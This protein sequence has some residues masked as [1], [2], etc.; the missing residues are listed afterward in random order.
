[1]RAAIASAHYLW[2]TPLRLRVVA[3][4]AVASA[5]YGCVAY[6]PDRK[7]LLRLRTAAGRAAWRGGR[8]GAVELRLLVGC[9]TGRADP[10]AAMAFA[11]LLMCAKAV[12]RG[13]ITLEALRAVEAALPSVPLVRAVL[14]AR[15]ALGL[16]GSWTHWHAGFAPPGE[17]GWR[18]FDQPLAAT[19]RWLR[20][21]WLY[22]QVSLVAARRPGFRPSA[23]GVDLPAFFRGES[24]RASSA[25]VGCASLFAGG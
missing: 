4:S 6:P 8:F 1:L 7:E 23:A 14:A 25:P 22:L 11:P 17:Q 21:R 2:L 12:R 9:P 16:D 13:W 5:S 18:P 10:A 15:R 20:R 24:P 19:L 3:A